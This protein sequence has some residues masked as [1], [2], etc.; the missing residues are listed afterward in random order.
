LEWLIAHDGKLHLAG[1]RAIFALF[2]RVFRGSTASIGIIDF[3]EPAPC[4]MIRHRAFFI[5]YPR[6]SA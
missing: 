6:Q 1:Q 2:F 3:R 4:K 5:F